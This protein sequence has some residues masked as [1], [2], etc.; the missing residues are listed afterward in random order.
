[1]VNQGGRRLSSNNG[2]N[3]SSRNM[4][5]RNADSDHGAY[6]GRQWEKAK[7][8]GPVLCVLLAFG[9]VISE[10]SRLVYRRRWELVKRDM[11]RDLEQARRE[12]E[13]QLT[14]IKQELERVRREAELRLKLMKQERERVRREAELQGGEAKQD[15]EREKQDMEQRVKEALRAGEV[16]RKILDLLT[17]GEYEQARPMLEAR[18]QARLAGLSSP[19]HV[20]PSPP[21]SR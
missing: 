20:P 15:V 17:Q 12:A 10:C 9:F 5:G 2:N 4:R 11:E 13:S 7:D 21:P 19:P 14:L 6:W 1:M 8:A 18:T 3:S 16:D